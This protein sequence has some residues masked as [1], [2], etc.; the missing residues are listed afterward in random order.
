[1]KVI[2][3]STSNNTTTRRDS[4]KAR[5][6]KPISHSSQKY[7]EIEQDHFSSSNEYTEFEI[8]S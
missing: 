3:G 6:F 2:T 1:M 5:S 8:K 7:E 4:V